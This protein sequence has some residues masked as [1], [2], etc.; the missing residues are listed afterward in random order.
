M[1]VRRRRY[2]RMQVS[3]TVLVGLAIAAFGVIRYFVSQSHPPAPENDVALG[4]QAAPSMIQQMGGEVSPSDPR[5]QLVSTVG[6][7]LVSVIGQT[8]WRFQFHLLRDPQTVNAFALPGGQIFITVALLERL[9]NEA[10]LAG[11]LGHEIGH[12][13]ERHSTK[14]MAKNSL[15]QS[16]VTAVA[17]GTSDRNDGMMATYAAQYA[18]QLLQLKYGRGDELQSDDHGVTYMAKAGYDPRQM[19]GVM[20]ILKRAS[21]GSRTPEFA[22]TH[23]DPGNRAEKIKEQIQQQWPQGVPANLTAGQA[24]RRG[25]PSGQAP[26]GR[27][28]W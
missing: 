23:P 5:A 26:S 20:E 9:E 27:P 1:K 4:L 19:I 3:I 24:L 12:V 8:P 22:S 10:Q 28:L 16:L 15:G 21:G 11:V 13:M 17:V 18:N 6:Q 25:I 14:Q 7:R 2:G